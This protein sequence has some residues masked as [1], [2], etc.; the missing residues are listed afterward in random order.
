MPALLPILLNH[1]LELRLAGRF[2][3]MHDASGRFLR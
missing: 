1:V 2:A 3:S